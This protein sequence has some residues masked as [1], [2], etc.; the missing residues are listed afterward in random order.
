[1]SRVNRSQAWL[2][3]RRWRWAGLRRV[4]RRL[5]RGWWIPGGWLGPSSGIVARGVGGRSLCGCLGHVCGIRG[6]GRVWWLFLGRLRGLG[7]L[8]RRLLWLGRWGRGRFVLAGCVSYILYSM[9]VYP[10]CRSFRG[11]SGVWTYEWS[12]GCQGVEHQWGNAHQYSDDP[13]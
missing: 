13:I 8:W 1:M 11:E 12:S 9:K 10:R 6:C 2:G 4:G 5:G 3:L 7:R